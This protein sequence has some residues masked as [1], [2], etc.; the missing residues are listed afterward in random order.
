M[1]IDLKTP[2]ASWVFNINF[3]FFTGISYRYLFIMWEILLQMSLEVVQYP[4]QLLLRAINMYPFNFLWQRMGGCW[5][6]SD[7]IVV[8]EVF[9]ISSE[10]FRRFWLLITSGHSIINLPE[11]CKKALRQLKQSCPANMLRDN[12][13]ATTLMNILFKHKK[14]RSNWE[15]K[16]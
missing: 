4:H 13:F 14:P 9:P 1:I 16:N 7:K 5:Q 11:D 8:Y 12:R 15:L 6:C 3:S 2:V 10:F